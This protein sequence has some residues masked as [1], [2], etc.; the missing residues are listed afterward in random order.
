MIKMYFTEVCRRD[1][2]FQKSLTFILSGPP[3][4]NRKKYGFEF[5]QAL[6]DDMTA[7]DPA[8]R[9]TMGEVA[10][11]FEAIRNSLSFWKLRSRVVQVYG[12]P[13]PFKHWYLGIK[14]ILRRVS[15]FLQTN[16]IICLSQMENYFT[17]LVIDA[18]DFLMN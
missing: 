14:H 1:R 11:R 18:T 6:A 3:F 12:M 16:L 15:A 7:E 10:E 13:L 2:L 4:H 9:P 17:L 5:M 8:R